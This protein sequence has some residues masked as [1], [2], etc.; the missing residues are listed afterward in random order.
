MTTKFSQFFVWAILCLGLAVVNVAC[1]DS[2]DDDPNSGQTDEFKVNITLPAIVEIE[3]GA[4]CILPLTA[5]HGILGTDVIQVVAEGLIYDCNINS[6]DDSGLSFTFPAKLGDGKYVLKLKRGTRK[7]DLGNMTVKRIAKKVPLDPSTTVYGFVTCDDQPMADVLVSD[8]VDFAKTNAEGVYQLASKKENGYV[9]VVLPSGYEAAE[10]NGVVPKHFVQLVGD[11]ATPESASFKLKK[12]NQDNHR[13]LF[14]GDI[15]LAN[16]NGDISQFTEFAK[17]LNAYY[18]EHST[19][20]TYIMTLGDMSWDIYWKDYTLDN[21]IE[22]VNG[23][24]AGKQFF[25]TIGNHDNDYATTTNRLA[26][27]PFRK[28]VGPNYYS[29]NIGQVHYIFLDDI[30]CSTYDGTTSRTYKERLFDYQLSWLQKDLSFV[31]K[32]TPVMVMMHA[33]VYRPS[34]SAAFKESLD[35]STSEL[36]AALTGYTVH[37]VTGHTHKNYNVTP[38]HGK[39]V[40]E[41]NVGAVCSDWWWSGKLSGILL[42]TDGTPSGFCISTVNGKNIAWDYKTAGKDFSHQFRSYDLNNVKF[43]SMSNLSG[44]AA[45]DWDKY[46]A[47]YPGTQNNEVLINV[48]NFNPKWKVEAA[49]EDGTKLSCRSETNYDPLHILAMSKKRFEGASSS[50]PNFITQNQPHFFRVKGIPDAT[51]TVVIT[52]TDNNGNT[53]TERMERPKAF[54]VATYK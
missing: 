13:I 34:G 5:G 42:S 26:K 16:R 37:F 51:S 41:H 36:L 25:H 18:D 49:L 31:D 14:L 52:V 7:K 6:I 50:T 11:E 48:W 8:G 54:D 22:K 40:Y 3:D 2:K 39:P 47:A 43:E 32:S 23:L 38:D 24:F 1:S 30:D 29:V 17:D 10:A 46:V 20:K 15:H 27:A 21:Y 35:G 19:V 4:D 28:I 12:A 9:F 53:F 33:P 44:T 45:K